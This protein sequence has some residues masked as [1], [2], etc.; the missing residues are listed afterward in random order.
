[1]SDLPTSELAWKLADYH[2]AGEEAPIRVRELPDACEGELMSEEELEEYLRDGIATILIL[3]DKGS[4]RAESVHQAFLNDAAFL[5]SIGRLPEDEYN[6]LKDLES[7][8][9]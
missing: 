2:A 3:R 9:F 6:E 8:R 5:L 7:Y 1:M 4:D